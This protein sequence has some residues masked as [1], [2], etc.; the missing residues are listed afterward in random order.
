MVALPQSKIPTVEAID[1]VVHSEQERQFDRVVRGSSIGHSCERYLWYRFRWAIEPQEFNG[2]MLRLFDTGHVE[3]ARMVA[4][5]KLAGAT[6]QEVDPETNEQWEVVAVDGHFKGHA[7]GKV[8]GIKEAPV[9][10]HLLECK[11]HNTK[12]FEQ[13]K[14]NGVAASKPEHVAQMQVYMHLLGLTRAFYLAKNKDNDELYSERIRYDAAHGMA[15]IAKAERIKEAHQ[16]PARVSDDPEYYLC[17]AFNCPAYSICHG[18]SFSLRNCRTCLHSSPINDGQW[19]CQRHERE[20]SLEDQ[21]AGCPLH[22]YLPS[23]VPGEQVDADEKAETVTYRLRTG[24][25]WGDGGKHEQA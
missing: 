24:E 10:E 3:E 16:A 4:W 1:Q 12:S 20:L 14:R 25:I 15:L 11:T 9:V 23:L 6:V 13:L 21:K 5:L 17:K 19:Y 7:D 22:L 18:G 2:R 8:T